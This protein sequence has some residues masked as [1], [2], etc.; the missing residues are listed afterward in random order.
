M[1]SPR[2]MSAARR[3]CRSVASQN[4]GALCATGST[5]GNRP[6]ARRGRTYFGS[7]DNESVNVPNRDN[8]LLRQFVQWFVPR[9]SRGDFAF[10]GLCHQLANLIARQRHYCTVEDKNTTHECE[11]HILLRPRTASFEAS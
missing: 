2:S 6:G 3:Y 1:P 4:K 7:L 8:S 9:T 11:D 5:I 10:D